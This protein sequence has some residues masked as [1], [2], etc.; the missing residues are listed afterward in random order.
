MMQLL[1]LRPICFCRVPDTVAVLDGLCAGYEDPQTGVNRCDGMQRD[2]RCQL[3]GEMSLHEAIATSLGFTPYNQDETAVNKTRV[4][5]CECSCFSDIVEVYTPLFEKWRLYDPEVQDKIKLLNTA[6][7][8][9]L[10]TQNVTMALRVR[11]MEEN[12]AQCGLNVVKLSF[13]PDKMLPEYTVITVTGL[14]G[15]LPA[16]G[17]RV[18][19]ENVELKDD[20]SSFVPA[21]C[22]EWCSRQGL[23]PSNG[24]AID[25]GCSALP[26]FTNLV[27]KDE[28][29][30]VGQVSSERCMRWCDK[31]AVLLVTLAAPVWA[32]THFNISLSLRNPTYEQTPPVVEVS[33]TGPGVYAQKTKPKNSGF[34]VLRAQRPP[35]FKYFLP[36]EPAFFT[37]SFDDVDQVWRGNGP[38]MLHTLQLTIQ[39]TIVLLPGARITLT[40]LVRGPRANVYKTATLPPPAIRSFV[41]GEPRFDKLAMESWEALKGKLVLRVTSGGAIPVGID[42]TFALEMLMPAEAE[43]KIEAEPRLK[44]E[45]T[46]GGYDM[47]CDVQPKFAPRVL[48]LQGAGA[49]EFVKK[50]VSQST[51]WPG[52]CNELFFTIALSQPLN[53]SMHITF[54]VSGLKG[55]KKPARNTCYNSDTCGDTLA[56]LVP[57]FDTVMGSNDVNLFE[58]AGN[59]AKTTYAEWDEGNGTLTMKIAKD[60]KIQPYQDYS[61]KI[62]L[63]NKFE[64][65]NNRPINDQPPGNGVISIDAISSCSTFGEV[66][67]VGVDLSTPH[68][69]LSGLACSGVQMEGTSLVE[70]CAPNFEVKKVSHTYPW[71]GCDGSPANQNTMTVELMPNVNMQSSSRII[72]ANVDGGV[73]NIALDTHATIPQGFRTKFSFVK[74]NSGHDYILLDLQ[75]T[76]IAGETYKFDF[77]F[78]N[79]RDAQVAPPIAVAAVAQDGLFKIASS[80]FPPAL[81]A[82]IADRT[83]SGEAQ[84]LFVATP[85]FV[86]KN[87][88]Q[89][90]PYPDAGNILTITIAA[91]VALYGS[92][93]VTSTGTAA[94]AGAKI[95][96]AGLHKSAE[97]STDELAVTDNVNGI[98]KST[99]SWSKSDGRLIFEMADNQVWETDDAAIVVS[100]VLQNPG[101]C[102]TSPVVYISA[103]SVD[104]VCPMPEIP[105]EMNPDTSSIPFEE[106]VACS[107]GGTSDRCN[108]CVECDSTCSS[109]DATPLKVHAPAFITKAIAQSTTWPGATNAITVTL[110]AN[111][112]LS[113]RSNIY[114]SGFVGSDA[115]DGDMP[116][117]SMAG[118]TYYF[119]ASTWDNEAKKLTLKPASTVLAGEAAIFVFELRNPSVGQ[120]SPLITIWATNT[121]TC[122][123]PVEKCVMDTPADPA[124]HPV[125]VDS[126]QFVVKDIVQSVPYTDACATS[127]RLNTISVTFATNFEM[128]RPT[129]VT[130]SGLM[131]SLTKDNNN[132]AMTNVPA[133]LISPQARW[134]A[135]TGSLILTLEDNQVLDAGTEYALQFELLN[136]PSSQSAPPVSISTADVAAVRMDSPPLPA[137]TSGYQLPLKIVMPRITTL[138]V[139]QSTHHPGAL[140]TISVSLKSN[141]PIQPNRGSSITISGFEGAQAPSGLISLKT[142][143]IAGNPDQGNILTAFR[144]SADGVP[145]AGSWCSE[146]KSLTIFF[147]ETLEASKPYYF[148]FDISNPTCNQACANLQAV[149][150]GLNCAPEGC[151]ATSSFSPNESSESIHAIE[152]GSLDACPMKVEAPTF[153]VKTVSECSDIP[154]EANTLSMTLVPNVLLPVGTVVSIVG[155]FGAQVK[156][157]PAPVSGPDAPAF[158]NPTWI[159]SSSTLKLTVQY[160][161]GLAALEPV[162]L[163]LAVQNPDAK[164]DDPIQPSIGADHPD[165]IIGVS[166]MSGLVLGAGKAPAIIAASITESST[167]VSS[168]NTLMMMMKTNVVV[169]VGALVTIKGLGVTDGTGVPYELGGMHPFYFEIHPSSSIP[170]GTLVLEVTSAIPS[171][172]HTMIALEV[173]NRA[174]SQEPRVCKIAITCPANSKGWCSSLP[175]VSMVGKVLSF[176]TSAT[177]TTREIGQSNP[178]PGDTNVLTLTLATNVEF[179][180]AGA[181]AASITIRGL[182]SANFKQR[183]VNL[184]GSHPFTNA[185]WDGSE[186]R[187]KIGADM[188]AGVPY[189][190]SVEVVNPFIAQS[191]QEVSVLSQEL[192]GAAVSGDKMEHDPERILSGIFDAEQMKDAGF[193][194]AGPLSVR[195]GA[196]KIAQISQ[197]SPYPCSDNIISVRLQSLVP[198]TAEQRTRIEIYSLSN[199][200]SISG[201]DDLGLYTS[202][203]LT[204]KDLRVK[205]PVSGNAGF[206]HWND[207]AD[208]LEFE[209]TCRVE[210]GVILVLYFKLVNPAFHQWAPT[211]LY[212]KSS[213]LPDG[214]LLDYPPSNVPLP[215]IYSNAEDYGETAWPM[216]VRKP[217]FVVAEATQSSSNPCDVNRISIALSTNVPLVKN[218]D[219]KLL[220]KGLAGT[221]TTSNT[222]DI[223]GPDQG[224]MMFAH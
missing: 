96:V 168:Y 200:R 184:G 178:Y 26:V 118:N 127:G 31:D 187:F 30:A 1:S 39:P 183:S 101:E 114:I 62:H 170:T 48:N 123:A 47:I 165:V 29:V 205:S 34:A 68:S 64:A 151:G 88:G 109:Q 172:V 70:V 49:P 190:F 35:E 105:V 11:I 141:A 122:D 111:I 24:S 177:F 142:I 37:K 108:A 186:L 193:D 79:P 61:F 16:T 219:P 206:G 53:S 75:D 55:M 104:T 209:V 119:G 107:A 138:K 73:R 33:A 195:N 131:G 222:L 158:K 128:S 194:E 14:N 28:N 208:K 202:I 191:V 185:S 99:A 152:L 74:G 147:S 89:S 169:P 220:I 110:R 137:L 58:S 13:H 25:G 115:D 217:A 145:G 163:S 3:D 211:E 81:T 148:S 156:K 134:S 213:N 52:E 38:G 2:K 164:Q 204:T 180:A 97:V 157:G 174:Q 98:L 216:F 126:P 124:A 22:S 199:A 166:T 160:E 20:D 176:E 86:I 215:G 136:P 95:T 10:C 5:L 214:Q 121:G 140:N 171:N 67:D 78:T 18:V 161:Y 8:D 93:A 192:Q 116:I 19:G 9:G 162:V 153:V 212:V 32:N 155:L 179:R 36:S 59:I 57:L 41:D 196:F 80:S 221:A 77:V 72:I 66:C 54:Q 102:T 56:T 201:T 117:I 82:P 103:S 46:R 129:R 4:K 188:A 65:I 45:A 43:A 113:P 210:A 21:E 100:V 7:Q 159:E 15:H 63:Q 23:C 27:G 175:E 90:S 12:M 150:T 40:G 133:N 76:M 182:Q 146:T 87:I 69:C 92:G 223:L 218:C 125:N 224:T 154:G 91:N 94:T 85:A 130:I 83:S 106:C 112:E 143:Q 139:T 44:I 132:F 189:V 17:L 51:C 120:R 207:D 198:M 149:A 197:S 135:S 173:K 71:P 144:S 6:G 84:A 167:V 60:A 181:D 42:T 203:D 50:E